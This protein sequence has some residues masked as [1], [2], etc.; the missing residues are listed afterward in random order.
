M[1]YILGIKPN[2]QPRDYASYSS[3]KLWKTNK[4][5]YRERY[6]RNGKSFETIET[7]FGH[8]GH[9]FLE[10]SEENREKSIEVM[11]EDLKVIGHIDWLDPEKLRF[12]DDK[13]SHRDKT[14]KVPWD[15]VKVR[16][17]EQLPFYSMLI[18]HKFGRVDNVCHLRWHET[19]FK[20]KTI[21]FNGHELKSKSREL[22]LT[23]KVKKFRR[24]IWQWE[25]D[26]IKKDLLETAKEIHEDYEHYRTTSSRGI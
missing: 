2:G 20:E 11:I 14:G 16:K 10:E 24:V 12:L 18:K 23:G 7:I 5:A 26:R 8:K 15:S 13:F 21:M 22:Q 6:Y 17:H 19:A 1:I 3:W 25:R 4:E 9:K